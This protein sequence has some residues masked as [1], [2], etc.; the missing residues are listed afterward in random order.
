MTKIDIADPAT[1][2][3]LVMNNQFGYKAK[4]MVCSMPVV[5]KIPPH[6]KFYPFIKS[7]GTMNIHE[8]LWSILSKKQ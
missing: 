5:V 3:L 2:R 7:D 8:V 4:V 6:F 1:T